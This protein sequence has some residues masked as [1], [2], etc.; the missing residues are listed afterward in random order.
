MPSPRGARALT[1]YFVPTCLWFVNLQRDCLVVRVHTLDSCHSPSR[2]WCGRGRR[3]IRRNI[4]VT[5]D[6]GHILTARHLGPVVL[7]K[8]RGVFEPLLVCGQHEGILVRPGLGKGAPWYC[9]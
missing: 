7:I 4:V 3:P 6:I 5:V 1:A 2:H 8:P 9:E